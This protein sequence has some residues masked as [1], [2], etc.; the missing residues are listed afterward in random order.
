MDN[1][2][3]NKTGREN[4]WHY[5]W[6]AIVLSKPTINNI[7]VVCLFVLRVRKHST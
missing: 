1:K 3:K 2:N 6:Y 4:V 5:V 7:V